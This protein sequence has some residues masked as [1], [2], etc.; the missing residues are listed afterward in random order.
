VV[1]S[2]WNYFSRLTDLPIV[3]HGGQVN[4]RAK[5][6]NETV[7]K[8]FHHQLR[9]LVGQ[10]VGK[11]VKPSFSSVTKYFGGA[12]LHPHKDREQCEYSISYCIDHFPVPHSSIR[13]PLHLGNQTFEHSIGDAILFKGRELL[14]WRSPLSEQQT[15]TFL[16]LHFVDDDFQGDLD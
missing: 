7:A 5:M 4:L 6:L 15:S 8:F 1:A 13:W 11:V 10:I 9:Y 12:E 2:L 16:F 3:R 14:H